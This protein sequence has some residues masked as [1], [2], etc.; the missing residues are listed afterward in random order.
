MDSVTLGWIVGVLVVAGL[1]FWYLKKGGKAEVAAEI[2]KIDGEFAKIKGSSGTTGG[3]GA[4]GAT[5]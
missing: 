1:A 3:T 2:T 4:S 5:K